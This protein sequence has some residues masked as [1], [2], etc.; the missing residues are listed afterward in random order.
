MWNHRGGERFTE[1]DWKDMDAEKYKWM[2]EDVKTFLKPARNKG[3][4]MDG[5][6]GMMGETERGLKRQRKLATKM[7]LIPILC[8]LKEFRL[9]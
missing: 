6:L 4:W 5:L 7:F 3:R 1:E 9:A 8:M 2:Q